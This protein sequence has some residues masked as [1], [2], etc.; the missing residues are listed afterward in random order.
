MYTH[1]LGDIGPPSRHLS[2]TGQTPH[3][4]L[5]S[6][7]EGINGTKALKSFLCSVDDDPLSATSV[8]S[9]LPSNTKVFKMV[10]MSPSDNS[11]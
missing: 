9:A 3:G 10:S 4:T 11:T 6:P 5:I 8:I 7:V 2:D 1:L